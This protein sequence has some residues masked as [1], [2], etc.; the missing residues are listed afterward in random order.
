MNIKNDLNDIYALILC[1]GLGTR[2]RSEIGETQKV[3][4]LV[5]GHPFLDFNVEL[6]RKQGVER[7]ILCTG[8]QSTQVED[9]YRGEKGSKI[10]FSS[11]KSPL[12]T[13]GA[14]KNAQTL[15]QSHPIFVFNGDSFCQ[16][17]L[18]AVLDF[19][20]KKKALATVVLS[21][22]K[23]SRD[24]GRVVI[25]KDAQIVEFK[26]KKE[27]GEGYVNAGIYCLDKDI[28]KVMPK[29]TKF[30]I[31]RDCFPQ[32]IGKKLYGFIVDQEFF[33]MGTPERYGKIREGL[34]KAV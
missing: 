5:D 4:A 21:K 20:K 3:M 32:W 28:F 26:E 8:F 18:S 1:G 13:G 24:Y 34:K 2:L 31:E 27:R 22:V 17:D 16:V 25:D 10:V 15:I 6:L 23:D 9:Y 19:H 11:E 33:D 30:S 29:E 7:I 14:I 12:G